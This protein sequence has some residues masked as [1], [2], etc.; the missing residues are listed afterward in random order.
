M[1]SID[2]KEVRVVFTAVDKVSKDIKKISGLMMGLGTAGKWGKNILGFGLRELQALKTT[3]FSFRSI[4]GVVGGA[5]GG[6]MFADWAANVE[7]VGLGFK[8]LTKEI[9]GAGPVLSAMRTG[10]KGVVSDMELMRVA[11]SSM[12]LGV[13]KSAEEFEVLTTLAKRLGQAT[14]RDVLSAFEDLTLG[15][16]RQQPKILDNIGLVVKVEQSYRKYARSLGISVD[17][18]D[19]TDKR[20]AFL[21]ATMEAARKA[22][23]RLAVDTDTMAD[24][25]GRLKATLANFAAEGAR[26]IFG[27]MKKSM[28]WFEKWVNTNKD[29]I[30]NFFASLLE[31]LG[32]VVDMF[33]K[34]ADAMTS[35][36]K[37]IGV[38]GKSPDE[39]MLEKLQ[40]RRDSIGHLTPNAPPLAQQDM[41]QWRYGRTPVGQGSSWN[42]NN[43]PNA[44][45]FSETERAADLFKTNRRIAELED[46]IENG[47]VRDRANFSI[48]VEN[49]AGQI[50]KAGV[51]MPAPREMNLHPPVN[52]MWEPPPQG[53]GEPFITGDSGITAGEIDRGRRQQLSQSG[54]TRMK[55]LTESAQWK[56]FG[57]ESKRMEE[58]EEVNRA[59]ENEHE[60]IKGARNELEAMKAE[61][62]EFGRIAA[63]SI[64]GVADS[65]SDNMTEAIMEFNDNTKSASEIFRDMTKSILQD[66]QRIILKQATGML[67]NSIFGGIGGMIFGGAARGGVF[68]GHFAPLRGHMAAGGVAG[69]RG[70]YELAEGRNSEAVVPLPDNRSIPVRF[71]GGSGPAGR[72]GD[73]Y[74][75]NVTYNATTTSQEEALIRRHGTV[76]GEEVMRRMATS[77][78]FRGAMAA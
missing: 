2:T 12:L 44:R 8:N 33:W 41:S 66:I 18:L 26:S 64:R 38:L 68:P 10:T 34:I 58:L 3:L 53:W 17:M 70:L 60:A 78:K 39:Q 72:G 51:G 35:I 52:M 47:D 40:L 77:L 45:V 37:K 27:D 67:V 62:F 71:V 29:A 59:W 13:G 20:Q 22:S 16:A 32:R 46:R 61:T 25:W 55:A 19:E 43:A 1:A 75:V 49:I 31:T 65:I 50:R 63:D 9:G 69:Q 4:L 36:A 57:E 48:W 42:L 21:T 54:E 28:E 7:T 73:T 74:V 30:F 5:A 15:I 14:G 24:A 23:G 6:K 56:G 11:N 76:I